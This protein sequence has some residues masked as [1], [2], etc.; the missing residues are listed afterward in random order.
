VLQEDLAVVEQV[1]RMMVLVE[2]ELLEQQ[3]L[4]VV[5]VVQLGELVKKVEQ[6]V[7]V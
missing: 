4:A 6:E 7:Q 5:A 2:M 1:D 3:T